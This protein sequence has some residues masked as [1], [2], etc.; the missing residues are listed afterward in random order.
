MKEQATQ[1]KNGQTLNKS[2]EVKPVSEPEKGGNAPEEPQAPN[3]DTIT[4]QTTPPEI[5]LC[6]TSSNCEKKKALQP[7]ILVINIQNDVLNRSLE[8]KMAGENDEVKPVI[9]PVTLQV[10]TE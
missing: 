5:P 6:P 3:P 4:K 8:V 10:K 7:I 9:I 1:K 2:E